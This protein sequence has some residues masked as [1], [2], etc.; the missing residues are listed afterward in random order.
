MT[1]T[2]TIHGTPPSKS[3]CYKIVTINGKST[4]AK[5]KALTGYEK[6]F[7]IQCRNRGKGIDQYFQV[8]G[9]V[10]YPNQRADLDNSLKVILDCLQKCGVIKNDNKCIS[11]QFEKYLDKINPRIELEIYVPE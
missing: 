10:F 8:F 3:N 4:L 5:S 9:K 6:N 11:L 7:F 2:E 1:I